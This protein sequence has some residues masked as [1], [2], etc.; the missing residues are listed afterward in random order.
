M[1]LKRDTDSSSSDIQAVWYNISSDW[2]TVEEI[3]IPSTDNFDS[4]K[5][6]T[7]DSDLSLAD[8]DQEC[9]K[10]YE[11]VWKNMTGKN[12]ENLPECTLSL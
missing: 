4:C 6:V 7:V 11:D 5:Y 1:R 3:C 2:A 8:I 10:L 12:Q 9:A